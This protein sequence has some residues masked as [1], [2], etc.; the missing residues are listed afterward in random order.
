MVPPPV[1]KYSDDE[2]GNMTRFD[3]ESSTERQKLFAEA[4]QAHRRRNSPFLTAEVDPEDDTTV[5]EDELPPW[6]QFAEKEFNLDVT[7]PE[8]ERLKD[9]LDEYREFRID[10]LESPEEAEGTNVRISARSDAN[11]LAGFM[12]RAFAEVYE[13]PEDYQVWIVD[14]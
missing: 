9:L 10:S 14:L 8:L 12:N 11:R 7:E 13:L 3:A 4:I 6:V 5:T 1:F 2:R